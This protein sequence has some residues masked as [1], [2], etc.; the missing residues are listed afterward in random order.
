M[1]PIR[2]KSI[3][4]ALLLMAVFS[5]IITT[6][7]AGLGLPPYDKTKP[8]KISLPAAYELAITALGSRTNEFHC[9]DASVTT[10]HSRDGEWYFTFYSTNVQAAPKYVAVE[11]GGKVIVGIG[12]W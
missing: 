7:Y 6:L 2:I 12:A 9:I 10:M 11:F 1:K 4:T 5:F 8:P 3:K